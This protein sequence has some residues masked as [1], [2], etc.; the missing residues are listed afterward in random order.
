MRDAAVEKVGAIMQQLLKKDSEKEEITQEQ[1]D[2]AQKEKGSFSLKKRWPLLVGLFLLQAALAYLLVTKV[3]APMVQTRQTE[4]KQ[5]VASES[6]G[7][8]EIYVIKDIIT[9]PAKTAGTRFVNVT[10]G[11][12]LERG[13][14]TEEI[15]KRV[16]QI[17]DVLLDIFCSKT[18]EQ[19]S[20]VENRE[21][22]RQEILTQVN[23]LLSDAK[24][25]GV[26]FIDFVL[27]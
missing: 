14:G 22:L 26:Y 19:L 8:G 24:V 5:S 12:E 7:I 10:L 20:G 25:I 15:E 9:N 6:Q 17:R 4:A 21:A 3:V 23:G 27:Q 11:L 13:A 18:V 2:E 1:Q 16:P